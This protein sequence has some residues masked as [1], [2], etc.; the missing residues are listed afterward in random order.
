MKALSVGVLM[1]TA[2]VVACA[3]QRRA[4]TVKS[5]KSSDA[6]KVAAAQEDPNKPV[7]DKDAKQV[8]KGVGFDTLALGAAPKLSADSKIA[9]VKTKV[10]KPA[11]QKDKQSFVIDLQGL[12]G[13]TIRSTILDTPET[14]NVSTANAEGKKAIKT[15]ALG[16]SF[17]CELSEDAPKI[18]P[19]LCPS[20]TFKITHVDA[21]GAPVELEARVKRNISDDVL[22]KTEDG[23]AFGKAVVEKVTTEVAGKSSSNI[24]VNVV[25]DEVVDTEQAQVTLDTEIKGVATKINVAGI[26]A[27]K[28][29]PANHKLMALV[30]H[31]IEDGK[32]EVIVGVRDATMSAEELNHAVLSEP[33]RKLIIDT[34][35]KALKVQ[36][37]ETI[38]VEGARLKPAEAAAPAA[39]PQKQDEKKSN[40]I[41]DI[42]KKADEK[43]Q[44]PSNSNVQISDI[45]AP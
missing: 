6:A 39:A 18:Q 1:L 28:E 26:K 22:V 3:P 45:I 41:T 43:K 5:V 42:A 33:D 14:V 4:P 13:G 27:V 36:K 12:N 24:I 20:F 17:A 31:E 40:R 38:V 16:A 19:S 7:L 32:L 29:I 30:A 21:N 23:K 37:L 35:Q 8:I 11:D 2:V 9:A 15:E 10:A 44:Q 25:S 34:T